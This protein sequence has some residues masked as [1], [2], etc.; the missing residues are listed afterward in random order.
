[1]P[2]GLI[3]KGRTGWKT[4]GLHSCVWH[5]AGSHYAYISSLLQR[6]MTW[7]AG[8]HLWITHA[9]LATNSSVFLHFPRGPYWQ[10]QQRGFAVSMEKWSPYPAWMET[11]KKRTIHYHFAF[12]FVISPQ[13]E[14]QNLVL[15][16]ISVFFVFVFGI[17]MYNIFYISQINM[18]L[19]RED[20]QVFVTIVTDWI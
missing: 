2:A 15:F 19:I 12:L 9:H 18:L 13:L 8:S 11:V 4:H 7:L 16:C 14:D 1:M 3:P 5:C 10:S 17:Y 6:E 20:T